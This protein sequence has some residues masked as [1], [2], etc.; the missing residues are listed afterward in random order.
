MKRPNITPGPWQA[1]NGNARTICNIECK[2]THNDC[3]PVATLK[4][5]D[6]EA[7]SKAVSALPE[8][9]AA[10]EKIVA[11]IGWAERHGFAKIHDVCDWQIAKDALIKAGYEFHPALP[12]E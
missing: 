10:L 12:L 6:H 2:G 11:A 1:C 3:L 8:C 7:N 9:L 4:G 5:P